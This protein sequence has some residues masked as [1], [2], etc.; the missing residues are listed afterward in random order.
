MADRE[1]T[2]LGAAFALTSW[3]DRSLRGAGQTGLVNNC[4][5]DLT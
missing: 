1:G 3:Y 4:N 5:D 2:G